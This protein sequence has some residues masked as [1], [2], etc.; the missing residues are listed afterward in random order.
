MIEVL[1]GESEAAGM[2]I[3]KE[4][5]VIFGRQEK[6]ICM[7]SML[8]I[9]HIREEI[10]SDYRQNLI[11]N[12]YTQNGYDNS[13]DVLKELKKAGKQYVDEKNR[14]MD[15]VSKGETIRIWYSNAPY[16]MCGFYYI[17]DLLKNVSNEIFVLK[18]PEYVQIDNNITASYQ[19]FGEVMPDKFDMFLRYEKKISQTEKRMFA[20]RWLELVEDNSPLRAVVNGQLIGVSEDFY[21]NFIYKHIGFEPIKEV[22]LI[23]DIIGNYQLGISDWWYAS[24]IE[25]MIENNKIKIVEDSERK[26]LRTIVC[27]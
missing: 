17:C 20:N 15:Y 1:F 3:A 13:Q 21:D 27:I 2:K 14:L 19:S 6:V 9:G 5:G 4:K 18:L 26:Y 10:D 16:A 22:R 11:F 8:D 24:R 25:Y 7:A 23:G 12:M